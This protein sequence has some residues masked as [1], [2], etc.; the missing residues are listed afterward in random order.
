MVFHKTIVS[1]TATTAPLPSVALLAD[2]LTGAADAVA[3]FAGRGWR[4][5]VAIDGAAPSPPARGTASAIDCQSR[6]TSLGSA[7]PDRLDALVA[8]LAEADV[9]FLKIDSL[10]RG[11]VLDDIAAVGRRGP[12]SRIVVTPANPILGRTFV[13]GRVL[14]DGEPVGHA[15]V[16][17]LDATFLT[18]AETR[19]APEALAAKGTFVVDAETELDLARLAA[20]IGDIPTLW[21]GSAGLAAALAHHLAAGATRPFD[22][23]SSTGPV[24]C[25]VGSMT[26]QARR[27]TT[28]LAA[29]DELVHV[30]LDPASLRAD[31]AA[32]SIERATAAIAAGADVVVSIDGRGGTGEGDDRLVRAV[33]GALSALEPRV[34]ALVIGGGQTAREVLTAFGTNRL[35]IVG[36]LEPGVVLGRDDKE[37]V[38]VTKSGS[39]GDDETLVRVYRSLTTQPAEAQSPSTRAR[40]SS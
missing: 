31:R 21:I 12:W 14:F 28:A 8:H 15:D 25:V 16:A 6:A 1:Q 37:R 33:A 30:E 29:V 40:G 26:E 24:L 19:T 36:E 2:D 32:A 4:S 23:V 5:T 17:V 34:G 20:C 35:E 27:Q 38:V 18:C 7:P 13:G 22:R 39:F 10:L 11:H 3:V 9:A